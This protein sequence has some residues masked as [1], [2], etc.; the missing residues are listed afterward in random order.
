MNVVV[1]DVRGPYALFR[2]PYAV[3]SPVSYP[4]PPPTAVFG[5]VG[6]IAGFDKRSYLKRI[7]QKGVRVG[8]RLLTP[9]TKYRAALNLIDTRAAVY[10]AKPR[11]PGP[12][13]KGLA[14]IQVPHEFLKN[15]G[16][17]IYFSHD[18]PDVIGPLV[19]QLEAGT[20]V[21][22]PC[23]GLAQCLADVDYRGRFEAV[24]RGPGQRIPIHS[25]VPLRPGIQ[26]HYARDG[27]YVRY[28]VAARMTPDRV[29]T[30]YDDVVV[31]TQGRATSV[32][33][34]TYYEVNGEHVL[35]Q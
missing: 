8:I 17:R 33:V 1:F 25:I 21:Y 19:T 7:G 15:V 20:S 11:K 32:D 13:V 2:K 10:F 28:R 4:V 30:R 14:H 34:E 22:T 27:R 26:V 35:F 16:Y 18:D 31:E 5:M 24:P 6:A 9:V 23:L 12:G 3:M 29:V